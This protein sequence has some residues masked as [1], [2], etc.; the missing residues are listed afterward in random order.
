A[1][2]FPNASLTLGHPMLAFDTVLAAR[3]AIRAKKV[4]AVELARQA[5]DRIDK[6]EPRILAFNSLYADRALDRARRVDEGKRTGDLAGV[7]IAIKGN[8]C[9]SFG[10]TTCSSKILPNFHSPYAATAVN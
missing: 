4:S 8:F 9:T 6:L 3:D 5:L 10:T 7:P 2:T 1:F